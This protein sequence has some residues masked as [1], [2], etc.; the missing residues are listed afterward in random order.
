MRTIAEK[1]LDEGKD[2]MIKMMIKNGSAIEEIARMTRLAVTR[3]NE[4]LK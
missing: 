2:E 3:I 4:L 1:Y